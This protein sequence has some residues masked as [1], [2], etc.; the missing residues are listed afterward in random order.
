MEVNDIIMLI[1]SIVSV[2]ISIVALCLSAS[3]QNKGNR[4]A[5]TANEMLKGQVEM[6]IRTMITDARN[7]YEDVSAKLGKHED[8]QVLNDIIHSALES[9][10][11]AYDEA[12]AKYIDSKVDKERFKK[13]YFEEIK[14]LVEN[15]SLT[16]YYSETQT[17][18]KATVI[19]YKEWNNKES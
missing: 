3:A 10:L 6:Q 15:E 1:I 11:N 9:C 14:Q 16:E 12:C 18:Y 7:R 4:I 5:E 2:I 8:K 19:V 13:L 17:R